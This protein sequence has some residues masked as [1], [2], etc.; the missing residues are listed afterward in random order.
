ML[1][2]ITKQGITRLL[3]TKTF[4]LS[5]GVSL[6]AEELG[7]LF[8][9]PKYSL[10]FG[11]NIGVDLEKYLHLGLKS[12]TFNL[13]KNEILNLFLKYERAKLT[14]ITMRLDA[15]NNLIIT[16]DIIVD[17]QYA[18]I[19]IPVNESG[20]GMALNEEYFIDILNEIGG[21]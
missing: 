6:I 5:S 11:N 20:D 9:I 18:T 15:D 7:F 12:A 10:F 14:T 8:S 3:E 17:R 21:N 2:G 16:A 4:E 19:D 1:Y 13:I